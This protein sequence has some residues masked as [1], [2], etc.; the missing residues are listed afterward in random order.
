MTIS[1]VPRLTLQ[2][3]TVVH[4]GEALLINIGPDDAVFFPFH[5][6]NLHNPAMNIKVDLALCMDQR[7]EKSCKMSRIP[8]FSAHFLAVRR[9]ASTNSHAHA[10][11]FRSPRSI[12]C[13]KLFSDSELE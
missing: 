11:N 3:L 4:K 9:T 12:S 2:Y 7:A 6:N 10:F 1:V 13:T 8:K 5:K